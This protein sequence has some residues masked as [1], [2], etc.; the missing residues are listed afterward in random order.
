MKT[1]EAWYSYIDY[2]ALIELT[3]DPQLRKRRKKVLSKAL[4]RDSQAEFVKLAH[5]IGKVPKIKDQ[6]PLIYHEADSGSSAYREKNMHSLEMYRESLSVERRVLLD[7][8]EFVDNAIKVVG[9]GSVGTICGIVLFF[10]AENDPLFLQVKEA[11]QSILE[12]YSNFRI[13]ATNAERVINGQKIMQAASDFFLGHYVREDG[14]HFYVRQLR[15]VKVKPL[16][17]IYSPQNMYGFARNCGWALARAHARS[18]DPCIIAGYIG[19]GKTFANAIGQF[20]NTYLDQNES[21]HK[22]L[23]SAIRRGTIDATTE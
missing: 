14:K 7:R 8:Y 4:S 11:R 5:V 13:S 16:V 22:K 6:P 9:I 19:K 18:G 1:L 3:S 21:D 12:P 2:Q 23:I 10:A 17:E 20:A 15:D